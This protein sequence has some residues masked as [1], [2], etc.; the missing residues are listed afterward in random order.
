MIAEQFANVRRGD[1]F[2][3]ENSGWPSELNIEQLNEIRKAKFAR[4]LCDNS[5]ELVTVQLFP[6]LAADPVS[7]P[8]VECQELPPLDLHKFAETV[9][10]K[11][12]AKAAAAAA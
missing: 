12:G 1:R 9:D 2:W 10:Y 6:M 4:V 8:R 7:N 3:Y 5:D 11:T